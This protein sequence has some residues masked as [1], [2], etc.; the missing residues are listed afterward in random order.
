MAR[1]SILRLPALLSLALLGG[2]EAR[3][4]DNKAAPPPIADA[5]EKAPSAVPLPAPALD[6]AA[7]LEAVGKAAS[8]YAAGVDDSAAQAALDGRRFAVKLRFGCQGP[9][10]EG[11]GAPLRWRVKSDS[12]L[13]ITATPDL[14][15]AAPELAGAVTQTVEAVEGFWIA[16]PWLLSDACPAV[17]NDVNAPPA[18]PDHSVGIAQY[19]TTEGSR[20]ERRSGRP[21]VSIAPLKPGEPLPQDG[22]VLLLEGRLQGW[23]GGPP[24]HCSTTA[25]GARPS[26]I[27]S[28]R[29]DRVAVTRPG[30]GGVIDEWT[31]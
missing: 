26:C 14:S 8:A 16:R 13:E 3:D 25:A 19:S 24:I 2:C 30:D 17:R 4:D 9:A 18:S 31:S 11:S 20:T 21:Y 12:S 23:P 22:F 7:L 5:V 1:A 29:L 15:L 6:R 28:V 10:E 27:A